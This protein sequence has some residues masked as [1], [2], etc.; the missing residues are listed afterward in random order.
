M[1][2]RYGGACR[3]P[4]RLLVREDD[5]AKVSTRITEIDVDTGAR[6]PVTSF[7]VGLG[8]DD[9]IGEVQF[10]VGL[11]PAARVRPAG[12]PDR[13]PWP[14]WLRVLLAAAIGVVVLVGVGVWRFGVRRLLD[15]SPTGPMSRSTAATQPG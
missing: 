1:I 14:M 8:A 10:A 3:A 11:L 5:P 6:T 9:D 7:D 13:G 12:D 15:H 4:G 2:Y